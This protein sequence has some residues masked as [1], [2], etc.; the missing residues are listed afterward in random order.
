MKV[1]PEEYN[2][3]IYQFADP[4]KFV[5]ELFIPVDEPIYKIDL[6]TRL[7]ETP[8]F[9]GVSGEHDAEVIWF[10]T[11]RFFDNFDLS[12]AVIWVQYCNAEGEKFVHMTSPVVITNDDY[13]ATNIVAA[14]ENGAEKIL[15][16]WP[17]GRDVTRSAGIVEFSFQFFRLSKDK[18]EFAYILNTQ[19]VKSKVVAGMNMEDAY[20]T[21]ESPM[22]DQ[23]KEVSAK[24][25]E[26][27]KDYNLYW[28][29]V[30]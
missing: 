26:F 8:K 5:N 9:L 12:E 19:P 29:E 11:D 16:A 24:L 13:R 30:E 7:S 10:W 23:L 2:R 22:V 6:N 20:D 18:K 14:G 3:L 1:S 15:I 25:D 28:I 17:I 27:S 4:N 21:E